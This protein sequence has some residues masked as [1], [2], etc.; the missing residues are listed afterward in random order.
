MLAGP[1]VQQRIP[2][3]GLSAP[4]MVFAADAVGVTHLL[5]LFL[6]VLVSLLGGPS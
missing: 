1:K 5:L 3:V 2:A 6:L 4:I